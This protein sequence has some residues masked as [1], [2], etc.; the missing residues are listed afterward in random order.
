MS[1]TATGFTSSS[2]PARYDDLY[3][4]RLFDP[5]A[6]LLLER[7]APREGEAVLDVACGPGTVARQAARA[8]GEHGRVVAADFSEAMIDIARR[9][10]PVDGAAIEYIV[11]P[12]AP[13][14]VGDGE[15]DVVTCQQGLQFFPD[16]AAAVAELHRAA[17]PGARVAIACWRA[18][19]ECDYFRALCDGIDE[20]APG[21]AA[22][23]RLAFSLHD[24]EELAALVRG[25][26]FRDVRVEQHELPLVFEGGLTQAL[27][28]IAAS[29]AGPQVD[30]LPATQRQA[31][32]A[33][34]TKRL[35][36]LAEKGE[37]RSRMISNIAIATR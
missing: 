19:D 25:G 6:E 9:K 18:V 33:S 12:A 32:L 15:F 13:L 31:L 8:V 34:V 3:V 22:Q 17:R 11:S 28:G 20:A 7:V 16:R 24:A 37:V 29:P 10:P 21:A 1:G 27:G 30:A 26:G 35:L 36:P 14:A 23:L 5:W 4:P 2:V